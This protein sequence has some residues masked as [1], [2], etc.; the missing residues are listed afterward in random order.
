M[1]SPGASVGI[2]L[3][4]GTSLTA[5]AATL[6]ACRLYASGVNVLYSTAFPFSTF[7]SD[8]ERF[9][10]LIEIMLY[11]LSASSMT[12]KLA[13]LVLRS[14]ITYWSSMRRCLPSEAKTAQLTKATM[15]RP[16]SMPATTIQPS[17]GLDSSVAS[18]AMMT[19]IGKAT[20]LIRAAVFFIVTHLLV[21]TDISIQYIS[22]CRR[23]NVRGGCSYLSFCSEP[24]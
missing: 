17:V 4:P 13:G 10:P 7:H 21:I 19:S 24:I 15:A 14:S 18:E 8:S 2:T 11:F 9:R 16:I 5:F 22:S 3:T 23:G 20:R 6:S 1:A 12:R